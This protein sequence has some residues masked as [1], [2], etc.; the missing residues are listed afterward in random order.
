MH[1]PPKAEAAP[2]FY[3]CA[4]AAQISGGSA[5]ISGVAFKGKRVRSLSADAAISVVDLFKS[6]PSAGGGQTP[7]LDDIDLDIR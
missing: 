2:V 6:Y 7:V 4:H 1:V 3:N 5:A